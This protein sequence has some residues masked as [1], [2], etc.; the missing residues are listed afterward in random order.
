MDGWMDA[1]RCDATPNDRPL[2][3]PA[4]LP[5]TPNLEPEPSLLRLQCMAQAALLLLLSSSHR[6]AT[7]VVQ[8]NP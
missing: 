3:G 5:A 8:Q 7:T 6:I 2:T 1:M 4:D